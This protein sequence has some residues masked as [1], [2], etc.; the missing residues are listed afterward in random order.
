MRFTQEQRNVLG[1]LFA[2]LGGT[3]ESL[4]YF[5][6]N[7]FFKHKLKSLSKN[8]LT[9]LYKIENLFYFGG[10]GVPPLSDKGANELKTNYEFAVKVFGKISTLPEEAR[11]K[12]LNIIDKECNP[13]EGKGIENDIHN[14]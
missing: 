6:D 4:Q 13:E 11:Q 10:K 3:T 12:I 2:C 1:W 14:I 9:E 8:L 5:N 7:K